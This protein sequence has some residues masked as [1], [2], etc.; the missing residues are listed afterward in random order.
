MII[1]SSTKRKLKTRSSLREKQDHYVNSSRVSSRICHINITPS[2]K[3]CKLLYMCC[4]WKLYYT[5][6][7]MPICLIT[8]SSHKISF[9]KVECNSGEVAMGLSIMEICWDWDLSKLW[10]SIFVALWE[11]LSNLNNYLYPNWSSQSPN[12]GEDTRSVNIHDL[13]SKSWFKDNIQ[14]MLSYKCFL[15][16]LTCLWPLCGHLHLFICSIF[17][18]I[19]E[20][21]T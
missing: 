3:K 14:S 13:V 1:P 12:W 21:H 9:R 17:F 7:E 19:Q 5:L 16:F 11:Y 6:A 2:N 4:N 8:I 20:I 18:F 10:E 15:S